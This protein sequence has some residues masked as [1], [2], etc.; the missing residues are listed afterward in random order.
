MFIRRLFAVILLGSM[1]VSLA[2][3][4][5]EKRPARVAPEQVLLTLP[6]DNEAV[7]FC[8]A[9]GEVQAKSGMGYGAGEESVRS[10]IRQR[11]AAMG[12][13]RR[14]DA[15]VTASSF[16]ASTPARHAAG[17]WRS[18]VRGS[19]QTR[20]TRSSETRASRPC[21]ASSSD[22]AQQH[23][24]HARYYSPNVARFLSVDPIISTRA[25]H[26]PQ[27]GGI[28]TRTSVTIR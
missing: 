14:A 17:R 10:T 22:R 15:R 16:A 8:T 23:L 18:G 11:A 24:M 7:E 26:S 5:E 2:A 21:C 1:T 28:A 6:S 12:R 3:A 25:P 13:E 20:E 4:E 27:R 9:L 19:W